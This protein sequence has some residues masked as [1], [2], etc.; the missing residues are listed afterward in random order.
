MI[1]MEPLDAAEAQLLRH[2]N[3]EFTDTAQNIPQGDYSIGDSGVQRSRRI[4][5]TT[6]SLPANTSIR[7][8]LV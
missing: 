4:K 3:L 2:E 1:P 8:Q 7:F 5:R 6:W